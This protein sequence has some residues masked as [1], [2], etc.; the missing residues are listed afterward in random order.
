[1]TYWIDRL[2]TPRD[3]NETK[4]EVFELAMFIKEKLK[5]DIADHDELINQLMDK[6]NTEYLKEKQEDDEI[7]KDMETIMD[8]KKKRKNDPV[9][10][11]A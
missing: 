9:K 7:F 6:A 5:M 10:T 1:M 3:H 4:Q 8:E 11:G 2:Y